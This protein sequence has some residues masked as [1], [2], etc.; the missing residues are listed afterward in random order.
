MAVDDGSMDAEPV[1]EKGVLPGSQDEG[2]G[3]PEP[4]SHSG[5][6]AVGA[7]VWIGQKQAGRVQVCFNRFAGQVKFGF[8][9][10]EIGFDCL[11]FGPA[12]Q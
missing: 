8:H 9:R 10:L 7:A 5:D 4:G 1:C 2:G 11:S 3:K 12:G 6:Q